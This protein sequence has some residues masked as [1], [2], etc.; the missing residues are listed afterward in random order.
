VI[1]VVLAGV[2]V[3]RL[4]HLGTG[5]LDFDEG[6]YWLS[7]RSMRAGNPLFTSVYSSQPPGFLLLIEP[8]WNWL[9]GSI[10]AGRAVMV[11]WAVVGVGSGAVLGWRLA[12]P[13]A[14]VAV[15]V[16]LAVDPRMV[17]QSIILQADGPAVSLGLLSLAA[18]AVAV[19]THS[20]R[21]RAVACLV[22]GAALALG[23]LT[24]LFDA[25]LLPALAVL[26]LSDR[27]RWSA[28]ALAAGGAVAVAAALLLPIAVAWTSM[29]D[30]AVGLHLTTRSLYP[31]ITLVFLRSF[32]H[33]EWPVVAVGALGFAVGWRRAPRAWAVSVTWCTGALAALAA[34]RPIFPHHMALLI[35]GLSL[36]GAI[37]LVAIAAECRNRLDGSGRLALGSVSAA[38]ATAA[39]LLLLEHA[40]TPL[41]TPTNLALVSRLQTLTPPSALV[42]SDDQFD[43]AVAARDAPAPFVDTSIVRLR[44]GGASAATIEAVLRSEP[45]AC[46]VLFDT[47]RLSG[48]PGFLAWAA[49]E[50]PVRNVLP[51]GAVLYTRP[52]CPT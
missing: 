36:L 32:V 19:S 6:V 1:V 43:Q 49:A 30:Q 22:A 5:P 40:L 3:T 39:A 35:P 24:K 18:A 45:R 9:G 42:I 27:R 33:A 2:V 48:V 28:M 16:A 17:N 12:G 15:A 38:A 8:L 26:L 50:Y 21:W 52:A 41:T 44:G 4:P 46:A 29:W 25:G 11:G 31:G 37:G 13:L 23:V 10:A 14:G 20:H 7:M 47:G 51:G 34:T